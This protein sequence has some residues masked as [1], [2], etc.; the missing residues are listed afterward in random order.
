MFDPLALDRQ[1]VEQHRIRE[2]ADV[3]SARP[4]RTAAAKRQRTG[5][6]AAVV[7]HVPHTRSSHDGCTEGRHALSST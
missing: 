3:A 6:V 1:R 5:L 4:A 7:A 2:R